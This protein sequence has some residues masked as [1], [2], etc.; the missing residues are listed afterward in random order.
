MKSS[1][2]PPGV[3]FYGKVRIP[4]IGHAKAIDTARG[5]ADK[6]GGQLRIGL[7]GTSHPLTPKTKKEHAEKIFNHSVETGES[8]TSNLFSYLSHLN[9]SHDHIHLVAGSD[10]APE[11]RK[12]LDQWNGKADK[13]GKVPFNFKSWKVHEVEGKREESNKHPTKMSQGE[14]EKSVSATKLEKLARAGDYEG[15]KAYHPGLPEKHVRKVFNQINRAPLEAPKPVSVKAIRAKAP[16]K[17]LKEEQVTEI[18]ELNHE[19]FGPMLDT[20]VQFASKKLGIKSLPT[21]EL[22]KDEMATSFAAYNPS[23]KHM[24][25]VT[26]NR[27]PMDIYRSVAHEL[28]HHKQNEDGKL[29][30][31]ISKEGATGSDIE[32]EAHSD[33]GKVMRWYAKENPETFKS[34]YVVES[35]LEEGIQDASPVVV[36]GGGAPGSGKNHIAK[37]VGLGHGFTEINSDDALEHLMKKRGLD[38]KMPASEDFERNLVRGK[39]K[40]LTKEKQRLAISG[41]LPLFINGTADNPEKTALIKKYLED[42]GYR[43]KML[44]VN[45]SNEVS[46]QRNIERGQLGGRKVPDGTNDKGV[47]DG[48]SDIRTEKWKA[49]QDARA[50]HRKMFGD[51]HYIEVDNSDDITKVSPERREE[52]EAEHLKLFKHYRKFVSTGVETPAAKEWEAKEKKKRSISDLRKTRATTMSQRPN[53]PNPKNVK[54][55]PYEPNASEIEQAKRLGV[56]HVGGGQFG[57]KTKGETVVS[58]VSKNGQLSM[59]EDLRKWFSKSDPKGGWKRINSK[60]EAIG[61]CAREPGEPKPKCM[62]NEKRASLS[63]KERA[64][65][66]A[67]KRRHDPDAERKGKPINVSNFGKGKISEEE[68]NEACW[69]GYTAKGM[70]KKGNRMVP[71]CVPEGK[72]KYLEEKNMPTNPELWSRAKS[73]ARQKFDVYPSAYANGWASKWYKSKGGGWKTQTDEAFEAFMEENTPSDREWGTDSLTKIYKEMTPGQSAPENPLFEKKK[74]VRKKLTKEDN[75]PPLGYEI[76]NSGIGQEFGVVRS[77]NGLGSGYSLPMTSMAESIQFWVSSEKTQNRFIE[78]YGNLA[79]Q[80]LYEAAIRLN[81]V[82]ESSDRGP[83]FFSQLREG[84]DKGIGQMGTVNMTNNKDEIIEQSFGTAF[85]NARKLGNK[86]FEWKGKKYT[87]LKKGESTLPQKIVEPKIDKSEPTS[88]TMDRKPSI[89]KT[90]PDLKFKSLSRVEPKIDKSEPKIDKSEPTSNTMDRKP[91]IT[92]T[93]PDLK[94]KSLSSPKTPVNQD[95]DVEK[96][97]RETDAAVAEIIRKSDPVI[98]RMKDRDPEMYKAMTEPKSKANIFTGSRHGEE[99]IDEETPAWQRKEGKN[100]EGGL[101][102]KGVASYRAAN[103]GSKLQT[104]VTTKPSKLKPGSKAANRRK[105]FC[106]RMGGMPG[107]MKDEKGKPTRKALSLRKWNCEE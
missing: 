93:T 9:K 20:F 44:F 18:G 64:S 7:S 84:F 79:E 87:S 81:E 99:G 45:T 72:M 105:S 80:K 30:K 58:H 28:V 71:N 38:L 89:T 22:K 17:K 88:N 4:T 60:G 46:R 73:M 101:N 41:R 59:N 48:S 78:K 69:T 52:I 68:T 35:Y 98:S 106:A 51:E 37:R 85:T 43:T 3:A 5:I 29:G 103:P 50:A 1:E 23:E 6:V 74:I 57:K 32:N 27:H 107:P 34:G 96:V 36:L 49:T 14:L 86:E 11:Y 62:S 15:F 75:M 19:K 33:A 82:F 65:A 47:P 54:Q 21:H 24:I 102:Q 83:K 40:N 76:G 31:D 91:S 63:K 2:R 70:K 61:P 42:L 104:A 39:A 55:P 94:F 77:P 56:D 13:T 66:V 95:D 67:A 97:K 100:P 92:K 53:K 12:T 26:K 16:P 90:T 8:H 10:R 25:V